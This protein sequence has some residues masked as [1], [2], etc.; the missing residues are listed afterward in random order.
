MLEYKDAEVGAGVTLVGPHRDDFYLTI[1]RTDQDLRFFGSRGQQRLAVLQLKILQLQI[2]EETLE[3][4]PV[5]LLDDI[6]SE[7]DS[8]HIDLVWSL[9]HG[10]QT[11]V[12][13]THE[14]FMPKKH[15]DI[16]VIELT[17]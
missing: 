7:L 13:T 12:T 2:V 5:L 14:E 6:F 1:D 17:K 15:K 8:E 11:I 10:G 16:E 3:R 4:K 9:T